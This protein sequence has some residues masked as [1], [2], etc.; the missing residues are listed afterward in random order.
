MNYLNKILIAFLILTS[1]HLCIPKISL[2]GDTTILASSG[3]TKN[4]PESV[5]TPEI[6]IPA[7]KGTDSTKSSKGWLWIALAVLAVAGGV[8]LA[9]NG[10]GSGENSEG[11]LNVTW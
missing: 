11:T 8:A 4:A 3:I 10:G 1:L 5:S 6:T 9:G 7:E 2:A